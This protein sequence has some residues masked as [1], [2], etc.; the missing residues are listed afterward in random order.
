MS[1]IH[2][3]TVRLSGRNIDQVLD[4]GMKIAQQVYPRREVVL[5]ETSATRGAGTSWDFTLRYIA[6]D[7]TN[8]TEP[9]P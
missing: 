1:A 4:G 6:A 3:I 9:T 8:P 5:D 7:P 2:Q